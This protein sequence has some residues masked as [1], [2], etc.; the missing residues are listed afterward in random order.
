MLEAILYHPE[1]L[2]EAFEALKELSP[3]NDSAKDE[4][5]KYLAVRCRAVAAQLKKQRLE[6]ECIERAMTK[7]AT[8]SICA[9][10]MGIIFGLVL[11]LAFP[12][13]FYS[14]IQTWNR[15]RDRR[16]IQHDSA[17]GGVDGGH[18][19]RT[20]RH[21]GLVKENTLLEMERLASGR[22]SPNLTRGSSTGHG[23]ARSHL[24]RSFMASSDETSRNSR[25][26]ERMIA[27]LEAS[28]RLETEQETVFAD[29][30]SPENKQT[31]NSEEAKANQPAVMQRTSEAVAN[32]E[33]GD[34]TPRVLDSHAD[35]NADAG[36]FNGAGQ[37]RQSQTSASAGSHASLVLVVMCGVVEAVRDV[38]NVLLLVLNVFGREALS[39]LGPRLAAAFSVFFAVFPPLWYFVLG[40]GGLIGKAVFEAHGNCTYVAPIN[41]SIAQA[42]VVPTGRV[43]QEPSDGCNSVSASL[44]LGAETLVLC[45]GLC[46]VRSSCEKCT[47][48]N[49]TSIEPVAVVDISSPS[50]CTNYTN[51]TQAAT[52]GVPGVLSCGWASFWHIYWFS[53]FYGLCFLAVL[54]LLL[55]RWVHLDAMYDCPCYGAEIRQTWANRMAIYSMIAGYYAFFNVSLNINNMPETRPWPYKDQMSAVFPR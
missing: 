7:L 10:P 41:G 1:H 24:K 6:T 53:L 22:S 36:S 43:W 13:R 23:M 25:V 5:C 42:E 39:D 18:T 33:S 8:N 17:S 21:G 30:T 37:R 26:H 19:P 49:S 4:E 11:L 48:P 2:V 15:L 46:V 28:A 14:V 52:D 40:H 44:G 54:T 45:N 55:G 12:W 3:N 27:H 20:P 51:V 9:L 35:D 47:W 50:L 31:L 34:E 32:H 29:E 16:R 38:Q